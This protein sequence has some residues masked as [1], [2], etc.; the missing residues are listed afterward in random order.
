MFRIAAILSVLSLA[1]CPAD[2]RLDQL[3]QRVTT[4]EKRLGAVETRRPKKPGRPDPNT[5]YRVQVLADEPFRGAAHAPVTLVDIYEYACP[6]CARMVPVMD[7][8][9]EKYGD[10]LKI[11]SKPFV[12]H[13]NVATLPALAACAANDQDRF[14]AFETELWKRAWPN[15]RLDKTALSK[16]ALTQLAGDVGLDLV[17]FV[18]DM[19]GAACRDALARERGALSTIGVRGTPSFFVNGK[20]YVGQRT[21][22]GFATVIDAELQR[23]KAS[24]TP[25]AEYYDNLMKTARPR[26]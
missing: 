5:V 6:Y 16:P 25:V 3:D 8:L 1:A 24:G 14:V 15:D 2:P 21:V 20:P 26:L 11:V 4:V 12:V 22:E 10:Q 17:R 23:V 19:D 9:T 13:P 18:A 7:A